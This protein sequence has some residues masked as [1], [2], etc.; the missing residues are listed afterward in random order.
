MWSEC[1]VLCVEWK[2]LRYINSPMKCCFTRRRRPR[3]EKKIKIKYFPSVYFGLQ[4]T[5]IEYEIWYFFFS[6]LMFSKKER[7][8]KHELKYDESATRGGFHSINNKAFKILKRASRGMFNL[9]QI[10]VCSNMFL[11]SKLINSFLWC[12]GLLTRSIIIH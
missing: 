9:I 4:N 1:Y 5:R 10:Y 2:R 7:R 12:F 11:T 3:K 8:I 6:C